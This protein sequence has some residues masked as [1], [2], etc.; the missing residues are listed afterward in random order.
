MMAT[1]AI[2]PRMDPLHIDCARAYHHCAGR[3]LLVRDVL[4]YEARRSISDQNRVR[5]GRGLGHLR[6]P[7][8]KH[9]NRDQRLRRSTAFT[10]SVSTNMLA[11]TV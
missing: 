4:L 3:P 6:P 10:K 11:C 2:E 1:E 8:D 7:W 9:T 5:P